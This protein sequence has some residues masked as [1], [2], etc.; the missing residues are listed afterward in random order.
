MWKWIVGVAT[1]TALGA[2]AYF[3]NWF[4]MKNSASNQ[5]DQTELTDEQRLKFIE[6]CSVDAGAQLDFE[7]L[8][9][10]LENN[11][12][13]KLAQSGTVDPTH[14][15]PRTREILG[16]LSAPGIPISQS[17][18]DQ[19]DILV[20]KNDLLDLLDAADELKN[21]SVGFTGRA[22]SFLAL[23]NSLS[24]S[25]GQ[26]ESF[27]GASN[28]GLYHSPLISNTDAEFLLEGLGALYS[29]INQHLGTNRLTEAP[30]FSRLQEQVNQNALL[31]QQAMADQTRQLGTENI[32]QVSGFV[33][34]LKKFIGGE[35]FSSPTKRNISELGR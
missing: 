23:A 28:A 17:C 1:A 35:Y 15:S 25:R 21:A 6:A 33:Q 34:A 24:R 16:S 26:F 10:F 30:N 5:V 18:N 32:E 9:R 11:D 22:N 12:L 19:A 8:D 4:G 3:N 31:W 2:V 29:S 20:I 7:A 14:Y 13:Q 27:I